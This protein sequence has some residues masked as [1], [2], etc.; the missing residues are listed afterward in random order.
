MLFR[1]T[2]VNLNREL[3]FAAL[4]TNSEEEKKRR[5]KKKRRAKGKRKK[6]ER[7]LMGT[8]RIYKE[9]CVNTCEVFVFLFFCAV[10]FLFVYRMCGNAAFGSSRNL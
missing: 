3:K 1:T 6:E 5:E 9:N 10:N 4:K 8:T 7:V 2:L